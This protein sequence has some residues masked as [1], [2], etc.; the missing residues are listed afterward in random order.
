MID[1]DS[2]QERM[3][4]MPPHL[5]EGLRRLFA[6]RMIGR[7]PKLRGEALDPASVEQ[8][9]RVGAWLSRSEATMDWKAPWAARSYVNPRDLIENS[10]QLRIA[11][12]PFAPHSKAGSG[13]AVTYSQQPRGI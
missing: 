7:G 2:L 11:P 5:G 4:A 10:A 1:N 3:T 13:S 9:G 8:G 6:A 12:A